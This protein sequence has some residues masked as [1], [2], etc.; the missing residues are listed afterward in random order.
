MG[1]EKKSARTVAK[2][3]R[4]PPDGEE[5]KK[6]GAAA[7]AAV[8]R[9]RFFRSSAVPR[10]RNLIKS[11]DRGAI[12]RDGG[13]LFGQLALFSNFKGVFIARDC[14]FVQSLDLLL[15]R[16]IFMRSTSALNNERFDS[17]RRRI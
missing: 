17:R 16:S 1:G 12:F 4:S 7:A 15:M 13:S 10:T 5:S 11:L 3:A 6:L 14:A 9:R 2:F 8:I